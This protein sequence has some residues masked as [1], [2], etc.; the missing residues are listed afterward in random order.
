VERNGGEGEL[1]RVAKTEAIGV[2]EGDSELKFQ[3]ELKFDPTEENR[4]VD[5]VLQLQTIS[6][7]IPSKAMSLQVNLK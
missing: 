4:R 3:T 5:E 1:Q 2:A 6:L 7:C